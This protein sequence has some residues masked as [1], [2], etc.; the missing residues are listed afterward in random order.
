MNNLEINKENKGNE[1][2]LTCNGRL[3]ASRAG[4]LNDYINKLVREG[5]YRIALDM[6]G[7]DYLSSAGIRSLITQCKNLQAVNG[8]FYIS[9]MSENVHQ[10]LTMV[11]M[12]DMLSQPVQSAESE[13]KEDEKENNFE[14]SGFFF[15]FTRLHQKGK[16]EVE[17]FGNPERIFDASFHQEDSRKIKP[18]ENR[19][20]IGLGAIGDSF[21]ECKSRFGEYII[22]GKNIAYLPSDGSGKPDY[23]VNSGKLE[24]SLTELYGLHF[25]GDFSYLL[26]FDPLDSQNSIG[27]SQLADTIRQLTGYKW[28]AIVMIAESG[29]LTGTS[30]N[31][32]PVDGI[33]LF[34]YPEIKETIRFTTEPAHVKMLTVSVG[35][36]SCISCD[37]GEPFL[38]PLEPDSQVDGHIHTAVFPYIPLKKS[39]IDL[40]ETIDSLFNMSELTDIL[41]LTNDSREISGIGESRFLQGFCWI[42]PVTSVHLITN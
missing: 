5:H 3:D 7:V 2:V 34:S 25:T 14:A 36:I 32:S 23:I 15:Q 13:V 20:S 10:V 38:R 42:A 8:H 29:G 37:E 28:M 33:T 11:G 18:V 19:F 27:L 17:V 22:M 4:Y 1:V 12:L 21:E 16:T 39:D 31:M 40:T 6:N 41:H 9:A 30:L 35:Y 26:R 24:A